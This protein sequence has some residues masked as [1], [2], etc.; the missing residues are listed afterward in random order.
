MGKKS[1]R[2]PS[3]IKISPFFAAINFPLLSISFYNS[4]SGK[5][6]KF[7]KRSIN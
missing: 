2:F 1:N 3:L 5:E 7:L 6:V 4:G